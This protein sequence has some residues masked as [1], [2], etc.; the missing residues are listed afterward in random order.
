MADA[1][2]VKIKLTA[3][4]QG[5]AAAIK[6]LTSQ[7][8]QLKEKEKETAEASLSLQEAFQGILEVLAVEKLAEFGKEV[9]DTTTKILKLSNV[10]GLSTETL[11]V[12]ASAATDAGV[13]FD[14]VAGGITKAATILTQFEQGNQKAAKAIALTGLSLKSFIG[15]N[16]EQK[17][18][19]LTDAI[20]KM[21]PGLQKTTAEQKL[22]GD[23]SGN[24]NRVLTTL[25]GDGFEKTREE[26]EKLGNIVG[27]ETA[28]EFEAL[29]AA[30]ADMK[31][32][33]EG[34]VRQ[35][36]AGLVPALTDV[37]NALLH[38]TTE[39]G[40]S[41]FAS[42]GE[43]AGIVLKGIVSGL[44]GVIALIFKVFGTASYGIQNLATFA[45]DVATKGFTEARKILAENDAE[46]QKRLDDFLIEKLSAVQNELG[47]ETRIAKEELAKQAAARDAAAR[48]KGDSSIENVEAIKGMLKLQEQ[49]DAAFK[50]HTAALNKAEQAEAQI[51]KAYQALREE[52]AKSEFERGLLSL[53][54]YH[55]GR[56]LE[57]EAAGR[58]ELDT[59]QAQRENEV[60]AEARAASELAANR[61]AA[62]REGGADTA[63]GQEFQAAAA[64]NRADQARAQ[65]AIADLDKQIT[66]QGIANKEKL[67]AVD[68]ETYKVG[69]EQKK[70]LAE[71]D[72]IIL[73]LQGNTTAAA[74]V[75]AEAK[76]AEYRTLLA[77]KEG[78][79]PESIDAKVAAYTRLEVASAAY[80]QSRKEGETALKN[81]ADQRAAIEDRVHAG[82]IFQIQ[83]DEEI[84]ALQTGQ[85][86]NLQKIAAAQLAAAQATTNEA[87][88]QQAKDFQREVNSIAIESAAALKDV[89]KIKAGLQSGVT[90]AFQSFFD[91]G[92]IGARN[93]G[94]AF[95]GLADGIVG[96]LRKI[97][98]QMLTT[99]IT[100]KLLASIPGLGEKKATNP[101]QQIAQ[102]AAAGAAKGAA[103]A[104]PLTAAAGALTAAGATIAGGAGT[105]TGGATALGV[106][107]GSLTGGAAAVGVAAAQLQAAADTMLLASAAGGHAAGGLITGPAG[108][109]VIPA[110]L[111][112]GEF[113]MREAAVRAIGP[114]VLAAMNRG[115][116]APPIA[117]FG[118]VQKFAEG[119][120]VQG[121]GKGGDPAKIHLQLGL[122]EGI[123]LKHMSSRAAG[124]VVVQHLA[125]NPK[126]ASKAIGRS[127]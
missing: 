55:E 100:E 5:V 46:D 70:K 53:K 28:L 115:L 113:V 9:F 85:L 39:G 26:A 25:A 80:E 66:V 62:K 118:T 106:A 7:L 42:L 111:T 105:L 54:E 88:I 22:L 75:E 112:A 101:G 81:L 69:Q 15:L 93:L 122:D 40:T 87:S 71:F 56:R 92:I 79:T 108:V 67:L 61:K 117:S 44:S 60:K 103:E 45:K 126:Q 1:P 74:K 19:L 58:A 89:A 97:V 84:E 30:I 13:A 21:P 121:T 35:F 120:L 77:S 51:S 127:K 38:A 23:S 64:K 34:I 76:E 107:G 72:K 90:G 59:L 6:G 48:G 37:A 29:R 20:A 31:E 94:Q 2:E 96:S 98:A 18:R 78:E 8:Q 102:E 16:S 68:L 123:V 49:Q 91:Q 33:S 11:S 24:L 4:D 125:N 57:I 109:D 124:K 73:D 27:T 63:T 65:Q 82:K 12:Y 114:D 110:R 99:K 32:A 43:I 52:G 119:G 50:A 10:T 104:A 41:G 14:D 95:A 17:I 36:E 47:G 83:A 116:R 3:E 86:A